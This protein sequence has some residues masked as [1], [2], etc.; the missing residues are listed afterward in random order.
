M[1]NL[2]EVAVAEGIEEKAARLEQENK[3]LRS[4][5][6]SRDK[7]IE[8]MSDGTNSTMLGL[9]ALNLR[10]REQLRQ[11]SDALWRRKQSIK[12]LQARVEEIFDSVPAAAQWRAQRRLAAREEAEWSRG[13]A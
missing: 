7:I 13:K 3:I 10:Q 9:E 4:Q 1:S 8:R 6:A 12:K 11:H 2:A 5:V